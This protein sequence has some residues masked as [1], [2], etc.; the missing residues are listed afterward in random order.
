MS[1]RIEQLSSW[2]VFCACVSTSIEFFSKVCQIAVL[3]LARLT[4]DVT[5]IKMLM[6]LYLSIRLKGE[7]ARLSVA[8]KAF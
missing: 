6:L 7:A 4:K 2:I 8:G 1:A 5:S 3:N